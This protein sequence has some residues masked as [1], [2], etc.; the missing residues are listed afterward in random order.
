MFSSCSL[1]LVMTCIVINLCALCNYLL[2][3]RDITYADI[4]IAAIAAAA[5]V[6]CSIPV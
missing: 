2:R 1:R 3:L 5:V 4:P 6:V